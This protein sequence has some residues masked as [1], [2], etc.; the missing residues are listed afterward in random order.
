MEEMGVWCTFH[1][2]MVD[3]DTEDAGYE[4]SQSCATRRVSDVWKVGFRTKPWHGM[5][6]RLGDW[7]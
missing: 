7:T 5:R 6:T 2:S 4:V 3:W 1:E